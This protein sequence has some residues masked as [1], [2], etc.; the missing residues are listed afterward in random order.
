MATAIIGGDGPT[1]PA[2]P[3]ERSC[4][5]VPTVSMA[6][7]NLKERTRAATTKWTSTVIIGHSIRPFQNIG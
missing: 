4:V 5:T 7:P 2:I 3:E 1:M 6:E